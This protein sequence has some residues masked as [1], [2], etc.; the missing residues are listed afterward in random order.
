[1][2]KAGDGEGEG[3]E[4]GRGEEREKNTQHAYSWNSIHFQRIKDR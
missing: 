2:L 1:M 3:K 4:Q